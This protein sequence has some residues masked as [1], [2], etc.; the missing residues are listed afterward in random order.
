MVFIWQS[1]SDT[2]RQKIVETSEC[3]G[4][5]KRCYDE[6]CNVSCDVILAVRWLCEVFY[7]RRR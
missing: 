7:D 6:V 4:K 2:K 3:D 1:V 5:N